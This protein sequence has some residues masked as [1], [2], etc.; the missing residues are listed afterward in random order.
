MVKSSSLGVSYIPKLFASSV[1]LR[2]SKLRFPICKMGLA[3]DWSKLESTGQFKGITRIS[4]EVILLG[5]CIQCC[6]I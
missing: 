5:I 3:G 2:I 6:H 4:I 1:V